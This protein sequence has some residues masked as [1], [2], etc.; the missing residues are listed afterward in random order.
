MSSN[1]S[2]FR[3]PFLHYIHEHTWLWFIN[4]KVLVRDD[5][6]WFLLSQRMVFSAFLLIAY[7][8]VRFFDPN[9]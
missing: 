1:N 3:Y 5:S 9:S 4:I 2:R 7:P 6:V 8:L